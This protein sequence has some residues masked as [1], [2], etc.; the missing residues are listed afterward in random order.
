M[1]ELLLLRVID[2][3]DDPSQTPFGVYLRPTLVPLVLWRA[4]RAI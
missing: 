3:V 2:C 4:H 1:D